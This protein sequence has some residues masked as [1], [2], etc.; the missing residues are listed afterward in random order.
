MK[1]DI[2]GKLQA[3]GAAMR[4]RHPS[5][6]LR[7]IA[8]AGLYGKTTTAL[9]LGELFQEAGK[10]VMTLTNHGV[11]HNGKSISYTYDTSAKAAQRC[12]AYARQQAVD[13]VII[14]VTA[15]FVKTHVLPTLTLEMSIVMSDGPSAQ[16]VLNQPVNY[17]VV[18]S[19][20]EVD[21]LSVAP[22]QAISYGEDELAEARIASI[23]Q[24]RKGTEVELV[25]DH[26]TTLL[27][28]THLVGTANA[29]NLAAAVAASY[30]LAVEIDALEE[31]AARCERVTG[32]YETL[33]GDRPFSMT[34]DG[35][36]HLKSF[37][38]VLASASTLKKRRVLVAL[39]ESVSEE[40]REVA[41]RTADRVVAVGDDSDETGVTMVGS[42]DE[43]L[44]VTLRGAKMDDSV[45]LLGASF[46][47]L[48]IDGTTRAH[49]MVEAIGE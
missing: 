15:S 26:Q 6:G 48:E 3:Q 47:N 29:Y 23:K 7:I 22:H 32:N 43:A 49:R 24:Y 36:T 20:L 31:G 2:L 35:A 14:E 11:F 42:I 1:R 44:E 25:I 38:L 12:L 28:T 10:S 27:L 33:A 37:E 8:V 45:L 41:K 5:K 40:A 13:V 21:G 39:D 9:L 46:A 16:A 17:T 19:G 30:V 34:V 4:Y 18:P